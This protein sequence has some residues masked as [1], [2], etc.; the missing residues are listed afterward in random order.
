MDN[1]PVHRFVTNGNI[2]QFMSLLEQADGDKDRSLYQRLLVAEVDRFAQDEER[3]DSIQR[4]LDVVQSKIALQ[5]TLM[6]IM[7][8]RGSDMVQAESL[9]CNLLIIRGT[10]TNTLSRQT[11]DI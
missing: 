3:Q 10:L 2:N 5:T 7:R 8:E 6:E 4:C 1:E 11:P 9:M